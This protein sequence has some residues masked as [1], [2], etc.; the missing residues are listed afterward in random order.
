MDFA[1][2]G[3]PVGYWGFSLFSSLIYMVFGGS[4]SARPW[5]CLRC[6]YSS[7]SSCY[8]SR[9]GHT[10]HCTFICDGPL[11]CRKVE[12]RSRFYAV[13][14]C[15]VCN[16]GIT[17]THTGAKSNCPPPRGAPGDSLLLQGELRTVVFPPPF[18]FPFPLSFPLEVLPVL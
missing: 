18:P 10:G 16:S 7:F 6:V 17:H 14:E 5:G 3:W 11:H 1:L 4:R 8:I 9:F 2:L 12:K 15:L 13:C